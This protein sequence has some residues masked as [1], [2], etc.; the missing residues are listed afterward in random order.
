[1]EKLNPGSEQVQPTTNEV[2][3]ED[4][5]LERLLRLHDSVDSSDDQPH[6]ASTIIADI[7][8]LGNQQRLPQKDDIFK[9]WEQHP[10][11]QLGRLCL[12]AVALPVTSVSCERTFSG[13]KYILNDLR[14]CM[15]EWY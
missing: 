12:V 2:E 3:D 13:L 15:S 5:P 6:S 8:G 4:D 11:K 7:R 14:M 10:N 1:M 9:F